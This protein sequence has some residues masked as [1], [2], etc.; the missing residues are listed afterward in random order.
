MG[1]MA[2]TH[3][4]A[5]TPAHAN[6]AKGLQ[7]RLA[8]MRQTNTWRVVSARA[9]L[10]AMLSLWACSV[11]ACEYETI[12]HP[13]P[14]GISKRYC[15]RQIARVMSW[16]GADWLN[17]PE[18]AQEERTD[19]LIARLELKPGMTVGDIGAGTGTLT[20]QMAEKVMPNGKAWAVDIQP[21]MV[22]KLE[23]M[24]A[25]LPTGLVQVRQTTATQVNIP[26]NTLDLAVMVDVYHEL[27]FPLETLKSL[28]QAV[29]PGGQVVFVEYR[30]ND[31]R[32]PIKPLHTMT[33][34]QIRREAEFAGLT[35]EKT[36]ASLP[37]QDMLVFKKSK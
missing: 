26:D 5:P 7:Q 17:R 10:S 16:Q 18:R 21:Q 8:N 3:S 6:D 14:D 20:R 31:M 2:Y 29:K 36:L 25:S 15:G 37:W 30:A 35:Y 11:W 24:A 13:H 32:V 19:L 33:Q 1:N 4:N 12:S 23:R 28:V 34:A 9:C 27:E 22:E